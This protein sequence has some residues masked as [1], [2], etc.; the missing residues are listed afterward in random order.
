MIDVDLSPSSEPVKWKAI[1]ITS[2]IV[3]TSNLLNAEPKGAAAY[4]W[5]A[6]TITRLSK[7]NK[8]FKF[9]LPFSCLPAMIKALEIMK[10]ENIKFFD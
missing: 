8:K 5:A 4:E 1:K 6:L 9:N 7:D 3:L 2:N 10:E